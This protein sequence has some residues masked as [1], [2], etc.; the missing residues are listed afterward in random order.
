MS[1]KSE[2]QKK[3]YKR[4]PTLT[5]SIILVFLSIV[6]LITLAMFTSFDEVTNRLE[7][8]KVDIVLIEPHWNPENGDEIVPNTFVEKDPTVKNKEETVNTYVFLEVI[9]PY[10]DDPNLIIE[11]AYQNGD[12]NSTNPA[13]E[14]IYT[15]K[16]GNGNARNKVPYYKFVATGEPIDTG[17][18]KNSETENLLAYYDN[19]YGYGYGYEQKINDTSWKL[20]KGYPI[21]DTENKTWIYVY[22]YVQDNSDLLQPLIANATVQMPLFNEIYLLNFRERDRVVDERT[23]TVTQTPF[24][25]PARN[26]SIR[27]NAYGMQAEFLRPNNGTT[28]VPE[29]VWLM[30]N[31][32]YNS[33]HEPGTPLS[34]TP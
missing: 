4:S 18:Y 2:N 15:N 9:V 33:R 28:N 25:D 6:L 5:A 13:G 1:E 32:S 19:G 26:Y 27:I 34:T 7:A 14:I 12:D 8:G 29:D 17:H 11:K 23:G 16:D 10:D 22:A 21:D 31:P 3:K 30:L 24:P 20:L